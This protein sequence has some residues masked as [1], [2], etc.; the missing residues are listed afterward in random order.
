MVGGTATNEEGFLV[1]H[2]LREGLGSAQL[3]SAGAV[4]SGAH[5]RA[6]ANPALGAEVADIDHAG[7]ILVL[8]TELVEE[9]PILDLRVRKA[10]R[11][12]GARLVVASSRPSTLDPNAAAAL[13]FAPGA[14]EAA[15]G[16]LASALGSPRAQGSLDDLAAK[17][18]ASEGFRP[19]A[20]SA[21]GS[22][23]R[24]PADAVRAAAD[25]LRDAGDVVVIWGERVASGERGAQALEALLAL[26]GSLGVDGKDESGLIGVPAGANG[27][28]LREVGC[29]AG[30]G[31]GLAD[32]GAG[33]APE[34]TALLLFEAELPEAE[35]DRY[36]GVVAFASFRDDALDEHA[37]VVFPAPV[38]AEKEGTVT[39]PDGRV[40]RVRQ[41]LGHRGESRPAWW[42]LA[43]LCERAGAGLGA[44]S[45]A[46][47]D[48][49]TRRGGA[50]LRGPH[51]RRGRRPGRALAGAR[52]RLGA[53]RRRALDRAAGR[54]AGR[55]RG[56]A[57][58][59]SPRRSGTVPR[60]STRPRCASWPPARAPSCRSRTRARSASTAATTCASRSAPTR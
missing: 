13:R 5:A 3:A 8:D 42:V 12:N 51:A 38:Y 16:A 36:A 24:S 49:G 30:I 31:P 6:L 9:A 54:P 43:E 1:Q 39:H 55:S 35:L 47:G 53:R 46:D 58:W 23:P 29:A 17:A 4:V 41:A 21:N 52:R 44:L 32:A 20:P 40:Q 18:R 56:P 10:V 15:L 50:L 59:R 37:D 25:F 11:R 19:G 34:A 48:R 33:E 7:A 2:L 60:P 28:G 45:V 57:A 22:G 26:A 27:R 14:V